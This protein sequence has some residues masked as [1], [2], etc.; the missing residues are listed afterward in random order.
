M[1]QLI[2][3]ENYYYYYYMIIVYRHDLKKM[4][5]CFLFTCVAQ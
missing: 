2:T 5:T 1:S 4:K 3:A